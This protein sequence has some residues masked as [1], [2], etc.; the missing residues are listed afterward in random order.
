M[1]RLI[2]PTLMLFVCMAALAALDKSTLDTPHAITLTGGQII[3]GVAVVVGGLWL[4][5]KR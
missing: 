4:M 1:K 3:G 5:G 2:F